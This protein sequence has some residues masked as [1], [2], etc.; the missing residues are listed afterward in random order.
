VT[1][2]SDNDF[3]SVLFTEG[4][5]PSSPAAS[6]QRLFVRSSDHVLCY[7]NS[8]GTVTAVGAGLSDPMTTRGDIIVRNA[9]NVTAR[10]GRGSAAQVLTSDGTDV[11]WAA[12]SGGG[13]LANGKVL[14]TSGNVTTTSTTFTDLTGATVTLTTGAHRCLVA[15]T[16]TVT[17]TTNAT[18]AFDIAVDGSRI[19]NAATHGLVYRD[20][21]PTGASQQ[22][23][24]VSIVIL[25]DVLSA[26]SHT[27]KIQ[28]KTSSGTATVSAGT[29]GTSAMSYGVTELAA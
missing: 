5:T 13:S 1:K 10:L 21:Y 19:G 17:V 28:W 11:A 6:H 12:P 16:A 2:A 15:F 22:S 18:V 23:S 9:S 8:S 20:N 3:P 24:P 25:T 27:I 14:V 4:T 7:V 26:A 29:T